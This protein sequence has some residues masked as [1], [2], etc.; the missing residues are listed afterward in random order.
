MFLVFDW[1]KFPIVHF[2]FYF[3]G[4]VSCVLSCFMFPPCADITS[5]DFVKTDKFLKSFFSE[6]SVHIWAQNS[7]PELTKGTS[8]LQTAGESTEPKHVWRDCVRARLNKRFGRWGSAGV[9]AQRT[10]GTEGV[11]RKTNF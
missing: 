3:E 4:S 7:A 10:V 5:H 2:L 11:R 9:I 1:M 8:R 6:Y